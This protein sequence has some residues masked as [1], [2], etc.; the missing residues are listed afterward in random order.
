MC[1]KLMIVPLEGKR[2]IKS[3]SPLC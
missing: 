3:A 2:V 1:A